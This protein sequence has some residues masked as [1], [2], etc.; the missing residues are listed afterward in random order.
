MFRKVEHM[1]KFGAPYLHATATNGQWYFFD[2]GWF[3]LS[4]AVSGLA[5]VLGPGATDNNPL[6]SEHAKCRIWVLVAVMLVAAAG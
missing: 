4:S 5:P 2:Y 6:D 1:V 3:A